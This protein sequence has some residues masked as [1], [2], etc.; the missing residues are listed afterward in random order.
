MDYLDFDLKIGPPD[1]ENRYKVTARSQVGDAAGIFTPPLGE[2]ELDQLIHRVGLARRTIRSLKAEKWR[3]A[4]QFGASLFR[5]A[6]SDEVLRQFLASRAEAE[7]QNKGLRVKLTLDTGA[8]ELANYPWEFL[9]DPDSA[10]F[11]ALFETSPIVRYVEL[12]RQVLPFN[13]T[14][15]LRILG[16]APAPYDYAELDVEGERANLERALRGLRERGL[17]ELEW[18]TPATLDALHNQLLQRQY[19]V[20]H[21]IGHGGFDEHTEDSMLVMEDAHRRSRHIRA[22]RIATLFGDHRSLRLALLNACEGA[23]E[24]TQDPFAGTAMTLVRTGNLPAVVAMQFEITDRAATDFADGFYSALATGRPIDAAVTHGRKAVYAGENDTEWSTPVLYLRARDGIIFDVDVSAAPAVQLAVKQQAMRETA[25]TH[26]VELANTPLV[27][28]TAPGETPA[29][30]TP[31]L[32]NTSHTD[33]L[34]T[35]HDSIRAELAAQ[36]YDSAL[37][38]CNQA[39]EMDA[40]NAESYYLRAKAQTD[41]RQRTGKGTYTSALQ[42]I[43]RAIALQP[44]VAYYL[45]R[46]EIFNRKGGSSKQAVVDY[47]AALVLEPNNAEL[48]FY[49]SKRYPSRDSA[50]AIRDLDRAIELNPERAEFYA[51]R[52]YF[53]YYAARWHKKKVDSKRALQ[54]L[55]RAIQ[56]NP[57]LPEAYITR[58]DWHE[59]LGDRRKALQDYQRAI[60]ADPKRAQSYISRGIF[61]RVIKD[62]TRA[63]RDFDQAIKLNPNTAFY[64]YLRASDRFEMGDKAGAREDAR[65]AEALGYNGGAWLLKQFKAK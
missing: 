29:A 9:Y 39:L 53:S 34:Q 41:K 48:Y 43:D 7:K 60:D 19:H 56:L 13:F 52:A 46:I 17:V 4:R 23:R 26:K 3:A 40:E 30:Q 58:G 38:L 24:G 59:L 28:E 32:T 6:L 45:Q 36:N 37:K 8:P 62:Y 51:S 50:K 15:P 31:T 18:V 57:T 16:M 47:T 12:A 42:D 65:K 25:L 55:E 14:P 61:F 22:E 20:F 21:F 54:D 63:V 44:R 35:L 64:Y 2:A 33:A 11:L 27:G 5:A 10:Q 49:R 1:G